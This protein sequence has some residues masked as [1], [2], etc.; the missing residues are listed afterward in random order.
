MKTKLQELKEIEEK[1]ATAISEYSTDDIDDY[2]EQRLKLLS[3][4]ICWTECFVQVK[5]GDKILDT[6][7]GLMVE[8][9]YLK[10][11]ASP[12]AFLITEFRCELVRIEEYDNGYLIEFSF[13]G[14]RTNDAGIQV[15]IDTRLPIGG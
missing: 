7:D 3:E 4:I 15:I 8:D 10:C 11:V 12:F 1:L 5:S 14:T 9:E 13:E 2:S 6:P